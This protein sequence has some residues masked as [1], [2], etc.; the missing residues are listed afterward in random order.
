MI[1]PVLEQEYYLMELIVTDLGKGD[2][3]GYCSAPLKQIAGSSEN[4]FTYY[5]LNKLSSTDLSSAETMMT[6]GDR[7]QTKS[8]GRVRCGVLLSPGPE[9]ENT[10]KSITNG[11]RKSGFIQIS[12]TRE[13]PWT[14]V[15]LNYAAPAA[16]W[17]LGNDVVASEVNMDDGN[18]YVNIRSLVSVRNNTNFTLDLCLKLK[19]SSENM[20]LPDDERKEVQIDGNEIEMDEYFE[21]EKYDPTMGW[22]GC[23]VQSNGDLLDGGES[24]QGPSGVELPPGWEWIDDWLL[25]K[26]SVNT[27]DGW[28]YAPDFERLKWPKSYNP[29]KYVNYLRQR[30]WVRNRKRVSGGHSKQQIFVGPL[31]PGDTLPLPLSGLTQS[32]LYILQLRPSN[33]SGPDEYHW[34]SVMD[35]PSVLE[36][37]DR[38][39]EISEICVSA[40]TESEELLYCSGTSGTSSNNFNG[41]WFCMS[42]QATEIAKDIHSDPIQDWCLVVKSPLSITNDLPLTAEYSVLE[43]QAS[44]HFHV[45]SRGIFGPGET[46]KIF[47]ADIRNPLYF[48]LLPQRG[49]LPIHEAVLISHPSKDPS[50]TISLRSSIS[51]RIVQIILE[52]NHDKEKPLIAKIVRVYSPYWLAT[53]RCPP[54]TFRLSDISGEKTRKLSLFQPKKSNQVILE[55]I[56]EEEIYEGYTIASALNFKQLGLSAS[57]TQFGGEHFGPVKDLS[58]LGDMDGSLDLCAYDADGN[59]MLLFISSKP[60]PYQSVPTKVISVRPFITFTNRLGQDIS[61]KLSSEDQPKVLRA[62]DA[63][64]SFVCHETGVANKLQVRLEDTLWSFPVQITNEDTLTLVLRKHDGT[65][66]FLR[67]EIRGYEEGSRFIVVF[68]LGST[69]GPIRIE[70]R[71]CS[72]TIRIRQS[73]F[74]DDAWIQLDPHST[75]IFSWEDPYGE[76]LV[77]TEVHNG[78]GTVILKL[79]LDKSEFFPADDGRLGLLFHV[80][81]VGDIKVARFVDE[82]SLGSDPN[83]GSG[84]LIVR[85]WRNSNLQSEM[86]ESTAPLEFIVELG[87][88]GVSLV[89]HKPKELSYLYL[90]RVFISYSTGYDGGTSSRF[91]LILGHVQLDNQLPLTLMPVLLAPEQASD[92]N[93]PVFKMTITI[94]NENPDGIQIYPYVYIR[95]TDKVWRL[96]IHEPIIWAVVDFYNNLQLDRVPQNSSVTQVD[97]EIRIDLIDVSEVRLKLSL[98]TAPAERPDG[99]LGVWSPILSAVGNAFKIQVHLRKVMHKGRFMR[100]SSVIPAIGNRIFRDL[101]HNPLHLIFSVDVLGMTSSTL[102]S[103]SKGFAELSTDGQFLQ[104]R[105]KQVWSRKIT[106]VG[107]G[108]MQ[109]TEALAQGFAFGVSGVVTKPVESARQNGILGLAHGLGRAFLGFIVQPV[110][111][112]LDFFSLTV[113]GIGASCTRCLE[114]INHKTTLQRI[115]NPRCI[116]ADSILKEYSERDALGQMILYL[117]EASRHFGC[118]EIFKEP[119]KFAWSDYYEDHFTVPYQRIALVTNK[120]VMLLQCPTADKMDKKPCKIMW[121]VPWEELIALELAKAGYPRPTHLILHLKTFRRSE[122]FVRVIKCSTEEESE[123]GEP[124]AVRICSVVPSSQRHVCFAWN[125]ADWRDPHSRNKTRIKSRG[126]SSSSSVSDDNKFVKH[127]INFSKIWSSEQELKARC[128]LYVSVG[129]IARVG[130]YP[131]NVAAVYRNSDQLFALPLG[132]DLV[133]RNCTDDYTTPVSIWHPRAPEGY[134]SPGCVTISSFTEPEL[135]IVYCVAE[136]RA[137]ETQFEEQ[138]V[139]SAP[140]SYP[141]ACHIYQVQSDALHFVALR[142][143]Q[144]DS[145]RKPMRVLDE[146]R[147]LVQPAE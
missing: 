39:K 38:P 99:V 24:Q 7:Y 62:T 77:D 10:E 69:N 90:E 96:N 42:I 108:I 143:T 25:D 85:S 95:V 68:R 50:K 139:W 134:I 94:R 27:A 145:D 97:P 33:T 146:P 31:K 28:V 70:N 115:R 129:D 58:P 83:E 127:S 88:V 71:T 84:S 126:L 63:R 133:W 15:R 56:T 110:S 75:T 116:R 82:R 80:L 48:S 136:S 102:A 117:A 91:K 57:I 92:M 13:G 120:R 36:D 51:G 19:A 1:V 29:L 5:F 98:E 107:D 100:K 122:P 49:W 44:G 52:L 73:G 125:E 74:I 81:E 111:G 144:E 4:S 112:A 147:D 61:L 79:D 34:S 130:I 43:M 141:W 66:K 118:T 93:H 121:D 30:R 123:G 76:R 106:G 53:A 109:G 86:E 114:V 16:C 55:E 113:D 78:S 54:L 47:N 124:Q 89:D 6:R 60:C 105:S 3:V 119:S 72:K 26:A 37:S 14:T 135:G 18:R 137:E 65:R 128:T 131:P 103:L 64:V 2:P 23:V 138:K 20:S 45:R 17:R 35:R 11:G 142:Q 59:S 67:T 140:E 104:L 46:V 41:I 12:P 40:L 21:T 132:Y 8:Y 101:I 22:I 9:I 32:G 87:V